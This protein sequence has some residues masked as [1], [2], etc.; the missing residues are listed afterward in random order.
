MTA[1][2]AE[3]AQA[4]TRPVRSRRKWV[5][6]AVG[7][8]LLGA[9]IALANLWARYQPLEFG[10]L[11]GGGDGRLG[12]N[13]FHPP[14]VLVK[15]PIG[16]VTQLDLS[17]RNNGRFDVTIDRITFPA[18]W[19]RIVGTAWAGESPGGYALRFPDKIRAHQEHD[20]SF[21]VRVS[22]CFD[23]GGYTGF[24]EMHVFFHALGDAHSAWIPIRGGVALQGV[25]PCPGD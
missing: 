12:A 16:H 23:P 14:A 25:R 18:G 6:R 7:V 17:L 5:L 3:P 13:P 1:V 4:P 20:Y 15:G 21:A 19:L 11:S 8:A 22:E 10:G 2:A 24:Q 9:F